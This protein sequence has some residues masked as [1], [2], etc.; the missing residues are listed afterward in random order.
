[1]EIETIRSL[2]QAENSKIMS[3]FT[4]L[5]SLNGTLIDTSA[6]EKFIMSFL[7]KDYTTDEIGNITAT[8]GSGKIKILIPIGIDDGIFADIDRKVNIYEKNLY[9]SGVISTFRL[10]MLL[11]LY[12]VIKT[13]HLFEKLNLTFLFY[14]GQYSNYEGLKYYLDK[15]IYDI[16]I[17]FNQSSINRFGIK[18]LNYA[19]VRIYKNSTKEDPYFE[20]AKLLGTVKEK[21]DKNW[22]IIIKK[23]IH[24]GKHGVLPRVGYFD[25]LFTSSKKRAGE[26]ITNFLKLIKDKDFYYNIIHKYN[27]EGK[28]VS[29]IYW[30]FFNMVISDVSKKESI[31]LIPVEEELPLESAI[32]FDKKISVFDLGLFTY[33]SGSI[34][35]EEII[36]PT[37]VLGTEIFFKMLEN[38]VI[39]GDKL[40]KDGKIKEII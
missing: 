12:K 8:L 35:E 5:I 28:K 9:G 25:I 19:Y 40:E 22:D 14:K 15:K 13:E 24:I 7:K 4:K 1:M 11:Q 17:T 30:E 10:A 32:L 18:P 23:I 26:A 20:L 39:L 33:L 21:I 36:L 2:F 27:F 6:R 31:A 16:A 38:I 34:S 37:A 3:N 29:S